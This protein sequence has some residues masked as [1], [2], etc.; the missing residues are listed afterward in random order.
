MSQTITSQKKAAHAPYQSRKY[1]SELKR[2]DLRQ[3]LDSSAKMQVSR[4]AEPANP[5]QRTAKPEK[6]ASQK[7]AKTQF[8]LK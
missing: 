4:P 2:A 1:D 3:F 8:S 5:P 6:P 7:Q